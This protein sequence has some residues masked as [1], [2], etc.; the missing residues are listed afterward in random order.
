[1][2]SSKVQTTLDGF[3]FI[4]DLGFHLFDHKPNSL[5][6]HKIEGLGGHEM[7]VCVVN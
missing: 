6:V 5:A 7:T 4:D 2:F 1:M 3:L